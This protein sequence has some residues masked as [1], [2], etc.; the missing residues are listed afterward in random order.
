MDFRLDAQV[1]SSDNEKVGEIER[2]VIDPKTKEVTDLIV[3]KGLIFT[4]DKVVPAD[5]VAASMG[6]RV[7]L[8]VGAE[9]LDD[10]SDF[11]EERYV[12]LDDEEYGPTAGLPEEDRPLPMYYYP[13]AAGAAPNTARMA[14]PEEHV[15]TEKERHIPEGT[16]A[17]EEGASVF[18][19]DGKE[20]G[21]VESV[22]TYPGTDR[23]WQFVIAEGLLLKEKK[24][25]PST[26]IS[27]LEEDR[28]HLTV[29]SR[30]L[31]RLPEYQPEA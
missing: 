2:I 19:S 20:M 17:L 11:E 30:V 21:S 27:T 18:S 24:L 3:S 28:V 10:L 6:D 22:L 26:W 5:L 29:G 13:T 31:D 23:A 7:S 9:Q 16:V 12:V 8:R 25:I 14:Y 1:V 15:M 4:E